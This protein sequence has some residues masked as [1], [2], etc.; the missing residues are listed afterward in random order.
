MLLGDRTTFAIEYELVSDQPE[1]FAGL[2]PL[3]H[4]S[5]WIGGRQIGN[6]ELP[7]YTDYLASRLIHHL[8]DRG[9]RRN[10]ALSAMSGAGVA[11]LLRQAF[12]DEAS[13]QRAEDERWSAHDIGRPLDSSEYLDE[14]G[15]DWDVYLV[16]GE[17]VGRVLA[18]HRG[19]SELVV[20]TA[21]PAG[22]VDSVLMETW[23][24]I[25]AEY[26]PEP[27]QL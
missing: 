26:Y 2:G 17:H 15:T 19:E 23:K 13:R 6:P 11:A 20:E 4:V 24:A 25:E 18:L 12:E 9:H 8:N 5:Y 22:W 7:T 3:L 1:P 16:E 21:V 27:G 14:L 10:D